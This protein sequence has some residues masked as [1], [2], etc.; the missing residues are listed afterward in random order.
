M[1][2]FF[3]L[4]SAYKNMLSIMLFFFISSISFANS[5][6]LFP[7]ENYNQNV[8]YWISPNDPHYN[9][10]ILSNTYQQQRLNE[11]RHTFFGTDN[12]D[13]SP[14]SQKNIE[15]LFSPKKQNGKSI[16]LGEQFFLS[17]F[18]NQNNNSDSIYYGRNYRPYNKNWITKIANNINLEQFNKPLTFS[19]KNRAITIDNTML[20]VLPTNDPAFL[21][22]RIAGQGYPFDL[23]QNSILFSGTSLYIIGESKNKQWLLV[24]S[25]Y[26][27][28][29]VLTKD[30]ARVDNKF[31]QKW[32]KS[33]YNNIGAVMKTDLSITDI[34]NLYRFTGYIGM[35]LPIES[36]NAATIK[37]LIP[38]KLNNG[39]AEI[40]YSNIKNDDIAVMPLALTKANFAKI[41]KQLQLRP[42]SWGGDDF[43]NDCSTET[44][45]IYRTFGIFVP[46]NS[47]SQILSGNL[48][49]LD[50]L[51]AE[52]RLKYLVKYGK[53]FLTII[54]LNGH[55]MVYL[56]NFI[57]NGKAFPLTY[58]NIW[59]LAPKDRSRRAVIGE[60]VFL[61]LL[62]KYPED[63]T[64]QSLADHKNFEL[65]Y[66]NKW[67]TTKLKQT[68]SELLY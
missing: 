57:K 66:I 56:G 25:P 7:I 53:A 48:V 19:E 67:P 14:W 41:L 50:K 10:P 62:I 46:R 61:P 33:A 43:Y 49:K 26:A 34:N 8:N 28:G 68:L 64:L 51:S 52:D 13:N 36:I 58:Q 38:I 29:W 23:I 35:I 16:Y 5:L 15:Y 4:K 39:M 9:K 11:L 6:S 45:I 31:I 40:S 22:F 42:Y 24:L 30:V 44:L 59:G 65:V 18:D 21:D 17:D 2:E 47:A 1:D 37:V 12:I 20:R 54:R 55:V 63:D 3:R 32:Q 60:A 27:I